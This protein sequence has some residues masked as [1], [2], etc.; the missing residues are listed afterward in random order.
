MNSL[1]KLSGFA[2]IVLAL[3]YIIAFAYF[4]AVWSYPASGS[5]AE[6]MAYLAENQFVFSAVYF[7]MY[8]VF[9]VVLA[10]LV[11][12]LHEKLKQAEKP[13]IAIASLFG[14]IWVGLV[15]AS[16]MISNIGLAYAIEI[17]D[18]SADKAFDIWVII[19]LVTESI[20]GGNELVG[21]I[22]V[23]L[24]SI[25]ALNANEFSRPLNY[26][27]VL[28]GIAGIA[29]TYPDELIT[30]IFGVTQIVWFIWLGITLLSQANNSHPIQPNIPN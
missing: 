12:G 30:E 7:L 18:A 26:L 20:G 29:T 25:V 15:I 4:G 27:G 6:K 28:V 5:P 24:I 1:Q 9:G 13:T 2:A 21:G 8:V 22:W 11:V 3:I 16:G 17:M 14:A 19:S 10:V 23:L